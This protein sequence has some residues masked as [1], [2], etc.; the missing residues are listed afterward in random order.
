V[1]EAAAV[2]AEGGH[3]GERVLEAA[4]REV[5]VHRAQEPSAADIDAAF[6]AAVDHHAAAIMVSAERAVIAAPGVA[7]LARRGGAGAEIARDDRDVQIGPRDVQLAHEGAEV[8]REV[9]LLFLHRT[10]IVDHEEDVG[11]VDRVELAVLHELADR[12]R[13]GPLQRVRVA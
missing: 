9:G 6:R 13:I 5:R 12:L 4:G 3:A 11:V 1:L 8:A 2:G 10:R 7:G